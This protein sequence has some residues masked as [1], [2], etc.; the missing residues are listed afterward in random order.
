MRPLARRFLCVALVPLAVACSGR[1]DASS[2]GPGGAGRPDVV[3]MMIDTLRADHLGCYGYHRATSPHIDRLA[4]RAVRFE[5]ATAQASWTLSSVASLLTSLYPPHHGLVHPKNGRPLPLDAY[6]LPEVLGGHGY[7]TAAFVANGIMMPEA[8]MDQG[9]EVYE[10]IPALHGGADRAEL[11][12]REVVSWLQDVPADRPML[13][14]V[15]YMD[16]HD[17]YC[18]PEG[19]Y[20]RFDADYDGPCAH[21]GGGRIQPLFE[22]LRDGAAL[23][24]ADRDLEHLVA[25]YD[26]EIRYVDAKLGELLE[27]LDQRREGRDRILVIVSDHGEQ[28]LEHGGLKHATSVHEE[29]IHVPLLILAPGIAP[30]VVPDRVE[31]VDVLPTLLELLGLDPV[32]PPD[33]RSLVPLLRGGALPARPAFASTHHAWIRRDG[34]VVEAR[35]LQM[36]VI[37]EERKLL[38]TRGERFL[39]EGRSELY[40]LEIDPGALVDRAPGERD[41]ADRLESALFD[42]KRRNERDVY[43]TSLL[44]TEARARLRERLDAIGY[45]EPEEEGRPG[46]AVEPGEEKT[47][48]GG[49]E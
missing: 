36:T 7:A 33:G 26:G 37:D 11:V 47:S 15:H 4:E 40:D 20:R 18:D 22:R 1:G 10:L 43:E 13:L 9:F 49:D 29:E 24:L 46:G 32:D 30:A 34:R 41:L 12:N 14:Y 8:Q 48:E 23:E 27:E 16:P 19:E 39:P 17:P 38:Y 44:S 35:A 5:R 25:R 42:W 2:G 21:N 28:F 3:V 45:T 6:T 31:L